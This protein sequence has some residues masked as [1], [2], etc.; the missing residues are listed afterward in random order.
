MAPSRRRRKFR[1]IAISN[2][3]IHLFGNCRMR[4]ARD[5][6]TKR[7]TPG[8]DR[9]DL[10]D[11]KPG[12][13]SGSKRIDRRLHRGD[14]AL[15]FFRPRRHRDV[16]E[17]CTRL[18]ESLDAANALIEIIDAIHHAIGTGAQ[19]EGMGER[20]RGI[21]SRPDALD[22]K[23]EVI[24]R[25]AV[26]HLGVF[27]RAARKAGLGRKPDRLGHIIGRIRKAV[28]E[29]ARY[30]KRRGAHDILGVLERFVA[31]NPRP[32]PAGRA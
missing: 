24:S 18:L 25:I 5:H 22:S 19:H 32:Y 8:A 13:R 7:N 29:I 16:D 30:R 1:E 4:D 15:Q 11:R 9:S 10:L 14:D 21:R 20:P 27:D 12:E 6:R 2:D 17:I 31:R 3:G 23:L 28:L 26:G